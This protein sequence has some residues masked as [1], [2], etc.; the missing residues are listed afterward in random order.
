MIENVIGFSQSL[1]H[2][3]D[4]VQ[5]PV[6]QTLGINLSTDTR[7]LRNHELLYGLLAQL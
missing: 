7:C 2:L 4:L 3:N 1:R 6:S 5:L